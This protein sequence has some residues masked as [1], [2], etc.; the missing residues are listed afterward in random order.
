M[1]GP[2]PNARR[3]IAARCRPRRAATPNE[4]A[5]RGAT[6]M[7]TMGVNLARSVGSVLVG[8][9]T[10]LVIVGAGVLV[11]LNPFWVGF[12]QARTGAE[13]F[14]GDAHADVHRVTDAI[15]PALFFGALTCPPQS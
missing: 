3:G 2:G 15:L 11:F 5:I 8:L 9:A 13:R 6:T 4:G 12:E 7:P 14:T 10:A 1:V